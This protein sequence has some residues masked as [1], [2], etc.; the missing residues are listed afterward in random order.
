MKISLPPAPRHLSPAAKKWWKRVLSTWDLDDS[1]LLVLQAGLEAFDRMVEAQA[2]VKEHGLVTPDRF[3]QMK[4][5]PA[6]LIERDTR[7]AML[8]AF[9]QLHLDLEPLN[10]R[11]GRPPAR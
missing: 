10:D 6:V 5:C 1:A 9:K 3:G 2:I 8:A 7:S 4:V 11:P